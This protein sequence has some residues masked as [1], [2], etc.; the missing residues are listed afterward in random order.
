MR[1]VRIKE[2]G[3]RLDYDFDFSRWLSP[4]DSIATVVVSVE[5]TGS[6]VIDGYD[7]TASAVKVWVSGGVSGESAHIKV[8]ITTVQT[9]V[10]DA[11]LQL[12]VRSGC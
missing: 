2:P 5:T 7:K 10:K 3:D 12:R 9:R 6:V 11:C 1:T 4:G 8:E